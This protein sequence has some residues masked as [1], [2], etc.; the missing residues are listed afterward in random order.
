M[1][2]FA[3]QLKMYMQAAGL[4]QT[5][6]AQLTG[7][8]KSSICEY[9]AGTYQPKQNNV[10]KIA[11]ALNILP[12]YLLGIK[13]PV[14]SKHLPSNRLR[15]I[16]LIGNIAAGK[17]ILAIQEFDEYVVCN[18][19]VNADFALRICGDS[20]INARIYDGDI[21]YIHEQPDVNDGDIAAVIVDD[22]ATL[23]RVYKYGNM[24]QLRAENPKY[25]PMEFNRND[26][27]N[28]RIIGKAV[29]LLGKII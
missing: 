20:M 26:C 21:V 15:R 9:L 16:P 22:A 10:L 3:E 6:L 24:V 12:E 5:K 13:I 18:D 1:N 11:T 14:K 25:R 4:T 23:K 2:D 8:N 28:I 27:N 17:P 29:A 7:I 19:D